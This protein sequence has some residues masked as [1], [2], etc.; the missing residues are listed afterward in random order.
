MLEH[1]KPRR[2]VPRRSLRRLGAAG[3]TALALAAGL[4]GPAIAATD[5]VE[6]FASDPL[7]G[8]GPNAFFAE[9]DVAAR[10]LYL[11][12]EPARFPGDRQG[13]LRVIY[14]T[15]LPAGRISAP[16]GRVLTLD[17]DFGFGAIL[18]IRSSG[19]H[20]DPNGFSQIAFGIWNAAT[21]G[22]NRTGFPSDSFDLVEFDYFPNVTAFGGPFLSPS[23]FGGNSGGN[24]FFNFAFQSAEVALPRDVPILVQARYDAA[25]RILR[26][27]VG[28]HA[29]G[30]I[31]EALPGAAVAVDLSRL[32]PTF[33]LDVA[34]I[35]AYFEGF[36]S[37]R[38]EVD[39]DLLY[40]GDLPAPFGSGRRI[41]ASP[42]PTE[43]QP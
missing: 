10:F 5:F 24:A 37:L 8:G 17:E 11:P 21:T 28:R 41:L 31:F 35:A 20:A 25:G 16:L 6:R 33:H 15:T 40:A 2:A 9:G 27:T 7:A 43:P 18:T 19:F 12:D 3:L 23:V 13:T 4:A 34:G 29:R 26:L 14:D 42:P 22:M 1:R 32:D 36:A 39:Y 38:A 30:V